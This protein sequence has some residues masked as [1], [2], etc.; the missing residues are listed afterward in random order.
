MTWG[1]R[2]G[3]R[4]PRGRGADG[5]VAVGPM[6]AWPWCRWPPGRGAD[7]RLAGALRLGPGELARLE[8]VH[9]AEA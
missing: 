5:C 7:G 6:A 1:L 2:A 4:W 3:C 8:A 9:L